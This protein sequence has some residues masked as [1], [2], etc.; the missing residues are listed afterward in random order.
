MAGGGVVHRLIP[1]SGDGRE[2]DGVN[3]R[4]PVRFVPGI[5][6]QRLYATEARGAK[7]GATS[8]CRAL[9]AAPEAGAGD[10]RAIQTSGWAVVRNASA[11]SRA[12]DDDDDDDDD[13]GHGLPLK[14]RV[15]RFVK[16]VRRL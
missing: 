15:A 8:R 16:R 7:G 5:P 12:D 14:D 13:D 2:D 1:V 9:L 4:A 10:Q 6:W 11:G 3:D